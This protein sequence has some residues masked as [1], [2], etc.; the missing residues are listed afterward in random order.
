MVDCKN[1][2]KSKVPNIDI[3]K[4]K[5]DAK[6]NQHIRVA[7]MISLNKG[8]SNYDKYAIETE[9]ENGVLYCYINSLCLWKENQED[10]LISCWQFCKEIYLNFFDKENENTDKIITLMKRDNNKKLIAERGRKK[11]KEI[12]SIVEQ[13]KT[14]IYE[15][16]KDLIEIIK[17]DVL[18]ENEDKLNS[19]KNWWDRS[20]VREVS[21][22]NKIELKEIY[23]KYNDSIDEFEQV[24]LNLD[25]FILNIKTFIKEEDFTKNKSKGTKK[26]LLNYNWVI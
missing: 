13:L 6:S 9:Y 11:I 8:I 1:F 2:N 4:F 23:D 17:G 26:Y 14:T 12:K 18:L 25:S 20:L 10:I 22:K 24:N 16:E 7:W 21:K 15:L 5:L 19:L 3:K